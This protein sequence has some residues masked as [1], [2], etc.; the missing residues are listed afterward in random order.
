MNALN[1]S[2]SLMVPVEQLTRIQGLN[3]ML[4]GSVNVLAAPL[5]AAL[6]GMFPIQ[7]V[8]LVDIITA[9][10]AM[11]PLVFT[12]IPQPEKRKQTQCNTNDQDGS[13][14]QS[15]G[16]FQEMLAGFRYIRSWPGLLMIGVMMIGIN[17]TV[18]PAFSL[19]PLLIKDYFGGDA[20][21]LGWTQYAMGIGVFGGGALLGVWGGLKNNMH[22]S[23]LALMGMGAG[24][25]TLALAPPQAILLAIGGTFVLGF[26]ESLT[27]GPFVAV[28]QSS[29]DPALQARIF[30]LL[31]SVGTA[32][33][34]L[35]LMLAGP[36]SEHFGLRI[37]F[38]VGGIA[39]LSMGMIGFFVPSI[40]NLESQ[41]PVP[42]KNASAL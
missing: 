23:L 36:V 17:F 9:I 8:L 34:P 16:V 31:S 28:V 26:M 20:M 15:Q 27:M 3:Q 2:T 21:Q 40:L 37:W 13:I 29:V 33:V 7:G 14:L 1:T 19:L 10:I 41:C 32:M 30:S 5:G 4:N 35:G 42:V 6:L 18:I 25:L 38:L 24:I 12:P 11:T 22:T 39:C